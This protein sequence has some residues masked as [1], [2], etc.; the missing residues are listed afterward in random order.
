MLRPSNTFVGRVKGHATFPFEEL[1]R[2][3]AESPKRGH[4]EFSLY[5][6]TARCCIGRRLSAA[7][8]ASDKNSQ[9]LK[10]VFRYLSGND[11][12]VELQSSPTLRGHEKEPRRGHVK[13]KATPSD[14]SVILSPYPVNLRSMFSVLLFSITASVNGL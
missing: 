10:D 11:F 8:K 1:A 5:E 7:K 2:N 12:T 6:I 4:S 3:R 9:R 14:P 13:G